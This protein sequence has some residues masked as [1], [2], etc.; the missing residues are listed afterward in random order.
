[1]P[2]STTRRG[3]GKPMEE[4]AA[5]LLR[6]YL[7]LSSRHA[8]KLELSIRGGGSTGR[9]HGLRTFE[10]Y[11]ASLRHAGEWAREKHGLRHLSELTPEQAQGFLE[12]RATE[13]IGQRHLDIERKVLEF[14]TGQGTLQ[15][16]ESQVAKPKLTSRFYTPLQVEMVQRAQTESNALATRIAHEAGLRA[17]ELLTLRRADEDQASWHRQWRP[18]RFQGREGVRYIVTGKGG[19]K[20]EVLLSKETAE[21]LEERRLGAPREVVDRGIRYRQVYELGGGNRWAVSFSAAS[22]RALGWSRGAHGL[23]HSY[24]QERLR[25]LQGLRDAE[26]K[27]AGLY[28]REAKKVVSQELGHFRE[29]IV[30]TYLR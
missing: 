4:Q 18:E 30:N 19:L 15:R 24:A 9:I 6:Q 27:P 3:K 1:M 23:R 29:D 17:H 8:A 26:G 21:R 7:D 10:K 12:H 16:V 20:R 28:Y 5:A 13:K 25:E 11:T 2:K 22:E 14:V